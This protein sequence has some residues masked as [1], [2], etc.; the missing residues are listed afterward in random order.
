MVDMPKNPTQP[1]QTRILCAT[2]NGKPCKMILYYSLTNASNEMNITTFPHIFCS[3][4]GKDKNNKYGLHNFAKRN[5]ADFSLEHSLSC[6]NTKIKKRWGK[7]WP[8]TNPH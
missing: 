7:L 6:L 2:F 3:N 5:G 8:F 4:R 1:N